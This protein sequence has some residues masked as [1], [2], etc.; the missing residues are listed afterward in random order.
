MSAADVF[1]TMTE[2]VAAYREISL[3]QTRLPGVV[4]G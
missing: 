3:E 4:V 1:A 2:H